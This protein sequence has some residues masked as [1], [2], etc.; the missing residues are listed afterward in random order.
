M[1]KSFLI[2]TE[3]RDTLGVL[4]DE[5]AGKLF[6]TMV[7]YVSGSEIR[8]SQDILLAWIP[9]KQQLDRDIDKYTVIVERNRSNGLKGGRP[10][11]PE[12]PV[13]S[14]V[15]QNNPRK[16][17]KADNEYDNDDVNENVDVIKENTSLSDK[18]DDKD[19]FELLW[20]QYPPERRDN[21]KKC[22]DIFHRLSAE[23]KTKIFS[24]L[25]NYL[26]SE[27]VKGGF[28]KLSL[29]WFRDWETWLEYE[30]TKPKGRS[31]I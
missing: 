8:V 16:P 25:L 11:N 14:L 21:K 1:K 20:K 12:N 27:R 30:P 3:I 24:A 5:Q 9:I 17:R 29:T 7:D 22:F 2:Y 6:K 18:S 23:K 26:D 31:L 28:C 4:S 15:T 13:G 10:R 19:E